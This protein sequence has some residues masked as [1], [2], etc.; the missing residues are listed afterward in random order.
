MALRGAVGRDVILA[1]NLERHYVCHGIEGAMGL[2]AA[3]FGHMPCVGPMGRSLDGIGPSRRRLS[4]Q[5]TAMS[6]PKFVV[7]LVLVILAVGV[8]SA[9]DSASAG[10]ILLRV[11]VSAVVI[12]VGYFLIVGA[13]IFMKPAKAAPR[14]TAARDP[15]QPGGAQRASVEAKDVSAGRTRS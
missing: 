3:R 15:L 2:V 11:V 10:T 5:M 6:L 12:Q 14:A 4:G 7:G 8:W 9:I 13:I 1:R